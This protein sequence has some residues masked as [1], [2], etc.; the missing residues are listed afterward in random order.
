MGNET[1]LGMSTP[2]SN[3]SGGVN[4]GLGDGSVRFI[5]DSIDVG[6]QAYATIQNLSGLSPFGVWGGETATG[7]D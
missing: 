6:N 4:V 7:L 1:Q 2:S 3:H 5:R